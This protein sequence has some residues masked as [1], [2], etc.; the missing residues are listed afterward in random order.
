MTPYLF[1]ERIGSGCVSHYSSIEFRT[2]KRPFPPCLIAAAQLTAQIWWAHQDEQ[3][4]LATRAALY[5][6]VI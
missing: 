6:C 2:Y 5:L 4:I 3:T 1:I